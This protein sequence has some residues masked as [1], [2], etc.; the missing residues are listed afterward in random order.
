[1]LFKNVK[2]CK[3]AFENFS[4]G[5]VICKYIF[6]IKIDEKLIK[7]LIQCL[8]RDLPSTENFHKFIAIQ[9]KKVNEM[10]QKGMKKQYL[11]KKMRFAYLDKTLYFNLNY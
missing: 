6:F 7:I 4:Y 2:N 3:T 5:D 10:A 9:E 8:F 1:M 11:M